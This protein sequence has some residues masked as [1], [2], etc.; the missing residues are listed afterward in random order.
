MD[1]IGY[2]GLGSSGYSSYPTN[3]LGTIFLV[4]QPCKYYPITTISANGPTTFCQGGSVVLETYFD[5]GYTYQWKRGA[6]TLTGQTSNTYTATIAGDY[7]CDVSTYCF[8]APTPHIQVTVESA[9]SAT[10]TAG[11][12]TSFCPGGS[13]LLSA[14]A[15]S[16]LTYQWQNNGI[17]I[18]GATGI[19]YLATALGQ[20][21]VIVTSNCG[22][23]TSNSIPVVLLT[24]PTASIT[25]DGPT[26]FCGTGSVTLSANTG[27]GLSYQ[28]LRN[29]QTLAGE[30]GSS[31]V[32]TASG[33]YSVV[34]TNG[35]GSSTSPV[36]TVTAT[37][38][39]PARP[40]SISGPSSV[41]QNDQGIVYSINAVNGA[42]GYTWSTPPGATIAGGQGTTTITV[43]FGK[44]GGNIKVF[45]YNDCGNSRPR[46]KKITVAK[47]RLTGPWQPEDASEVQPSLTVYPNPASRLVTARFGTPPMHARLDLFSTD[48]RKV[49]SLECRPD[50]GTGTVVLA[51]DDLPPGMYLLVVQGDGLR[52]TKKV[53]IQ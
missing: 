36:I 40:G 31:Y 49:R 12:P 9:P 19:D 3:F 4:Y 21:R 39:S 48:G 28:W 2:V 11:G 25:A 53:L 1:R 18:P 24:A 37:S 14:N 43:N 46:S 52:E 5:P 15:G 20:Y 38:S 13:V 6:L 33:D 26:T 32:A 8:T 30:T 22:S 34:V 17:D 42:S 51:V 16:G 47:C 44:K 23:S 10:A 41:C 45:A 50:A 7:H 35:C 27:T 29:S